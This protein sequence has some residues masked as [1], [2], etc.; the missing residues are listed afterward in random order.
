M[1]I[2]SEKS[3]KD[4]HLLGEKILGFQDNLYSRTKCIRD[5][6]LV[7]DEPPTISLIDEN[8]TLVRKI[9]TELFAGI[10]RDLQTQETKNVDRN[11]DNVH[12]EG[13]TKGSKVPKRKKLK[14]M[15][16]KR[17]VE[18]LEVQNRFL[19]Q[20]SKSC[21]SI[22]KNSTPLLEAKFKHLLAT[23]IREDVQES[24]IDENEDE[25]FLRLTTTKLERIFST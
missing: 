2:D 6:I 17:E 20:V 5:I 23:T 19:R 9:M 21:L 8:K 3:E 1:E 24:K 10:K 15:P 22:I 13:I 18:K 11:Q 7:V 16:N 12:S 4:E 25:R 14:Y